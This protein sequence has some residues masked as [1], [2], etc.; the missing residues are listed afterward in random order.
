M[1]TFVARVIEV[2]EIFF[3]VIRQGRSVNGI[4]M[5]LTCD[6]ATSSSEIKSWDIVGTVPGFSISIRP[7]R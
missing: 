2:D 1:R 4:S 6:M 7:D 5:I 3:P